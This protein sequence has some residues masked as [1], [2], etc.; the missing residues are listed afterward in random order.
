[1]FDT[2]RELVTE[3]LANVEASKAAE[4]AEWFSLSEMLD[5]HS[6]LARNNEKRGPTG[7][8]V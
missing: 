2:Y 1:M 5:E 3:V 6:S 7:A 8:P 4:V